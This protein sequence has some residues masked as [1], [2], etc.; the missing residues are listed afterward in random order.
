MEKNYEFKAL[1]FVP[2]QRVPGPQRDQSPDQPPGLDWE[3]SWSGPTLE[4]IGD[5]EMVF[6]AIEFKGSANKPMALPPG[7]TPQS[8]AA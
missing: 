8:V 1:A 6:I 7:V 3:A 5:R 4:N 2:T